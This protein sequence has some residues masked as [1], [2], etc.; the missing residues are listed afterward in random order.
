MEYLTAEFGKGKAQ[1]IE[2]TRERV[3]SDKSGKS[4]MEVGRELSQ[5]KGSHPQMGLKKGSCG[6]EGRKCKKCKPSSLET[7]PAVHHL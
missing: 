1:K 3:Q 7:R 2:I 6:H 5:L 4:E